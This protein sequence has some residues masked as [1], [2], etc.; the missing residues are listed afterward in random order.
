MKKTYAV[1][2][3]TEIQLQFEDGKN[4]NIT[5]DAAAVYHLINDFEDGLN[6]SLNT[7][8]T[9]L[10]ARI[11]YAGSVEHEQEMSI[12]KA[13]MIV[14]NLDIETLTDLIN[15][16]TDSLGK[17]KKAEIVE[18]QKKSMTEFVNKKLL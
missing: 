13:R 15:D 5:F 4:L 18:Y 16:F 6:E 8:Y 7:N 3:K 11:I 1:K 12:E 17:E 2:P 9:E 14:S 10:C